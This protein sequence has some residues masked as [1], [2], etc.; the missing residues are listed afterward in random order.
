MKLH[1]TDFICILVRTNKFCH[2]HK[3]DFKAQ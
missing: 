3:T 1:Y 2:G